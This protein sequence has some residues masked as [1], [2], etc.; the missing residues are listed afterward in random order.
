MRNLFILPIE[1][2]ENRYPGD[3]YRYMPNQFRDY[4]ANRNLDFAV[5][6]IDGIQSKKSSGNKTFLNFV[7]TVGWKSSQ[8]YAVSELFSSGDVR[9]GDVFLITDGWNPAVHLIKYML[10]L[11]NIQATL[12]GVFHAGG[13]DKYDIIPNTV[14]DERWLKSCELSM[15]DAYDTI[16]VSTEFHASIIKQYVGHHINIT[17]CGFPM[18]YMKHT[19]QKYV[20]QTYTKKNQVIFPHR[21]SP[22]KNPKLA[23]TIGAELEK[24]GI[25]YINCRDQNYTK[26]QYY[27]AL[28]E[29]KV[30]LSV[31]DQETLGIAQFEAMMLGAYP[32][33]PDAL[34]YQ[35]MYSSIWK[36]DPNKTSI[37]A[38]VDK[39][40]SMIRNYDRM[41]CDA[42][43]DINYI[44]E[45]FF[46]G[47]K[48]Y[49]EVLK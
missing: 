34:S 49:G 13:W 28:A 46:T 9:D 44:G 22:E 26:D 10:E 27:Q 4:I 23:D 25:K 14:K 16:I 2:I 43:L 29:S 24:L 45:K 12:V 8:C 6:Q 5:H 47:E 37:L 41:S 15:F 20:T 39:I 7:D 19:L 17:V 1:P 36:Y 11:T 31:S 48:F 3:W 35:E 40:K 30:C 21:N 42:E 38:V 33:V 18:E 32:C